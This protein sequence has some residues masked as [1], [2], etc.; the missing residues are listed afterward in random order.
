MSSIGSYSA[1]NGL[2]AGLR[3][4]RGGESVW[5]LVLVGVAND[6][7]S[8]SSRMS[9]TSNGRGV[10]GSAR[11]TTIESGLRNGARDTTYVGVTGSFRGSR[12]AAGRTGRGGAK[13]ESGGARWRGEGRGR[14]GGRDLDR[15]KV[16][17]I[18]ALGENVGGRSG[19]G[20]LILLRPVGRSAPVLELRGDGRKESRRAGLFEGT[21]GEER[22]TT[23]PNSR[24]YHNTSSSSSSSNSSSSSSSSGPSW[25][26]DS[27]VNS[28]V[29]EGLA[30]EIGRDDVE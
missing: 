16:G 28:R 3:G 15:G 20:L 14:G 7:A 8:M 19:R 12:V 25:K 4:T 1:Q 22:K 10:C 2:D 13:R 11:G 24:E 17:S 5:V 30:S 23:S 21:C 9:E 27:N 6:Q 26:N 18:C 29:S